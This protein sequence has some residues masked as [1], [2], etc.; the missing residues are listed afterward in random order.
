[1]VAT[2]SSTEKPNRTLTRI[3]RSIL[4]LHGLAAAVIG[5][6]AFAG[7][8]DPGWGDLQR[9]DI[10]MLIGLWVAGIIAMGFVVRLVKNQWARA[11]ILLGGPFI[12]VV[13]L[14]GASRL[15]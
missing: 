5:V 6:I 15:G 1:M 13:F 8:N 9:L 10:V 7:A 11:G 12:G 3:D 4:A 14:L 2:T